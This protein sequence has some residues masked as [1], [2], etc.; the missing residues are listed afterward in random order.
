MVKGLCDYLHWE[1]ATGYLRSF[2]DGSL[3]YLPG[4]GATYTSTSLGG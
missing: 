4:A 3:L 1:S 2:P